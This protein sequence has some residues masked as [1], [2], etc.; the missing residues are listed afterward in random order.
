[1]PSIKMYKTNLTRWGVE[2]NLRGDQVLDV[3]RIKAH[4][5]LSAS[6]PNSTTRAVA[7]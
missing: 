4:A 2:K 3:L 5:T 6:C 1:M 7:S